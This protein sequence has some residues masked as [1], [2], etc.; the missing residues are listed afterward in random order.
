MDVK[1]FI[2]RKYL[3]QD[4][5]SSDVNQNT[6]YKAQLASKWDE[7]AKAD[8][9]RGESGLQSHFLSQRFDLN[10]LLMY[11]TGNA[12]SAYDDVRIDYYIP[13]IRV[14]TTDMGTNVPAG[15]PNATYT[16]FDSEGEPTG[17]ANNT[18][19]TWVNENY[20]ITVVDTYSY[21]LSNAGTDNG[22]HMTTS[23]LMIVY[24][25]SLSTLVDSV[26]EPAP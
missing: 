21:F 26:P 12:G 23:E 7:A 16:T 8:W 17:T 6:D 22:V 3:H 24:N 5:D 1:V 2:N 11:M 19:T 14:L 9:E 25:D 4:L 10:D 13:Y 18:W 20:T 15:V